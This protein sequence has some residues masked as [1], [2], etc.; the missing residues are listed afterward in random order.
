[1]EMRRK[2]FVNRNVIKRSINEIWTH[3][4]RHFVLLDFRR[5]LK[6]KEN[7]LLDLKVNLKNLI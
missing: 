5:N 2:A 3:L 7:L 6:F 4:K 1:L